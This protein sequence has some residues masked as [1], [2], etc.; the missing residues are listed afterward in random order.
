M[1]QHLEF[2][3]RH[4]DVDLD[5]SGPVRDGLAVLALAVAALCAVVL[6]LPSE[7]RI[8]APLH[9][10]LGALLGHAAFAL[11]LGLGL[12]A[13][14]L[15]VRSVRPNVA[16]PRRRLIGLGLLALSVLAADDH[17]A[18]NGGGLVGAWLTGQLQDWLGAPAS[19]IVLVCG[20][21]AGTLLTFRI[22]LR[23]AQRWWRAQRRAGAAQQPT[24]AAWVFSVPR[25]QRLMLVP[26]QRSEREDERAAG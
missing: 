26:R 4:A 11:P 22:G 20:L 17:L 14:L 2:P 9:D 15:L 8:A 6:V 3:P 21:I 16:L 19:A 23:D 13:V 18:P 12:G 1:M 7:G 24:E 5:R 25:W 10:A